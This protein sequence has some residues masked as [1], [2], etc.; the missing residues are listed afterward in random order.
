MRRISA[1][2]QKFR[3]KRL[4][5]YML[6]RVHGLQSL[7]CLT[8]VRA[9]IEQIRDYHP[10]LVIWSVG[11]VPTLPNINGLHIQLQAPGSD[12]YDL[13]GF[14]LNLPQEHQWTGKTI[15]LAGGGPVALDIAEFFAEHGNK[16]TII[17][18]MPDI[19][20]GLDPLT[21]GFLMD[22]F[23]KHDATILTSHRIESVA[24]HAFITSGP[25]GMRTISFDAGFICLGLR[26]NPTQAELLQAIQSDGIPTLQ[27]GDS[28]QARRIYE[29]IHEGYHIVDWLNEN[30]YY[31]S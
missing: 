15:V 8:G 1:L 20:S 22:T 13:N 6:G 2:P 17:E 12:L 18:Q 9:T 19:G 3:M 27:I 25:D 7:T 11:S 23:Q 4:L 31:T 16:V 5:D 30:G 14:L 24:D 21:K 29:A 10:D 26:S 28:R